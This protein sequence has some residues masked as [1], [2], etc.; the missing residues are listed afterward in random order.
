MLQVHSCSS[1]CST[2]SAQQTL[3]QNSLILRMQSSE[4]CRTLGM[5]TGFSILVLF[6]SGVQHSVE[7]VGSKRANVDK[8]KHWWP[9]ECCPLLVSRPVFPY[10]TGQLFLPSSKPHHCM[11]HSHSLF[12]YNNH[13]QAEKKVKIID[14]QMKHRYQKWWKL[15]RSSCPSPSLS[16]YKI[17]PHRT[18]EQCHLT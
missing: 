4:F 15:M 7:V 8:Y 18:S 3:I 5:V 2:N 17:V 13:L 11:E 12:V 16:Q 14:R 10:L 6:P 1:L 9:D